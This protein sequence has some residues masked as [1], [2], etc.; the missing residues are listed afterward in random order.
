LLYFFHYT[1]NEKVSDYQKSLI[2][3]YNFQY[4]SIYEN[5]KRLSNITY[6]STLNKHNITSIVKNAYKAD[7]EAQKQYRNKLYN[8]LK[9]NYSR[10][11]D[12]KFKQLHFHYPDNSS[13]LRMH[14]PTKFGDNLSHIRYSVKKVNQNL[15]PIEGF[16]IGKVIHGFRFVYP[17]FDK[18]LKHVGSVEASISSD[19]IENDFEKNQ[20]VDSHF[21]INKKM[22]KT[23]MFPN[24][25]EKQIISEEN[26]NYF[27]NHEYSKESLHFVSKNFYTS[28]ELNLIKN[29]MKLGKS[30]ILTKSENGSFFNIYFKEIENIEKIKGSAYLVIYNKSKYLKEIQ[31]SFY[32][33]N[34]IVLLLTLLFLLII[35]KKYELD[36]R[37]EQKDKILTQQSKMASMG[38]MIGNIAHQWRQPLSVISTAATGMKIQKEYG[39][40]SDDEFFENVDRIYDNTQ[41]LSQTIDDFRNFFIKNKQKQ[42]FQI[43]NVINKSIAIFGSSFKT[44]NIHIVEDIENTTIVS[45]S[46]EL[47]QVI[48]NLLKNAKDAIGK[49]GIIFITVEQKKNIITINV[50]DSGN[51]IPKKLMEKIF[52]PYFTTKHQSVGTGL[53]LFMSHE[54]ITK[55]MNGIFEVKNENFSYKFKNYYG[56]SFSITFNT[57]ML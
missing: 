12:Y 52:E 28:Y 51:G 9:A 4:K 48:I 16:E 23:K 39:M 46:N 38:E 5:F 20:N 26:N 13:F 43:K 41:Y 15:K 1:K 57:D 17:L 22:C 31:L 3:K 33:M 19:Y 7:K 42:P 32:K 45:Y 37:H 18:Q 14:K 47:K 6:Y 24:E 56:A 8:E 11:I 29:N 50:K 36:L 21:L 10:L 2:E 34:I 40:L 49:D 25:Y 35:L 30:F 55:S 53:G 54:I 44:N 27:I